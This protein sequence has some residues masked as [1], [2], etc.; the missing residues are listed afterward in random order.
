MY[1]SSVNNKVAVASDLSL[2]NSNPAKI[3][4]VSSGKLNF[5]LPSKY[6]PKKAFFWVVRSIGNSNAVAV[7][8][9]FAAL[10]AVST[11]KEYTYKV[12]TAI[13][14]A[15]ESG[16]ATAFELPIDLTTQKKAFLG[17]YLDGN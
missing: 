16:T 17:K 1:A 10:I 5:S 3:K 12:D 7:P 14:A 4:R 9:S 6:L 13:K 2:S 11:L 15:N 8:L